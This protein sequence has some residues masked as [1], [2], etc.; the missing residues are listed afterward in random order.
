MM[1]FADAFLSL[2]GSPS[3]PAR[4]AGNGENGGEAIGLKP[5]ATSMTPANA[6]TSVAEGADENMASGKL[7]LPKDWEKK[8]ERALNKL[9]SY[10]AACF[11]CGHG[12]VVYSARL[13]DEHFAHHCPDAPQT[14]KEAAR[15]RLAKRGM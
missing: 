1:P 5:C 3:A 14:L 15:A 4:F 13:E 11:W 7:K 2:N 8:S 9:G 10:A 12:Y 6:Q